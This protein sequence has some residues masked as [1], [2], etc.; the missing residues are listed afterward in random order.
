MTELKCST[1]QLSARLC[2]CV[3]L[4]TLCE[5]RLGGGTV[6][7]AATDVHKQPQLVGSLSSTASPALQQCLHVLS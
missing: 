3:R 2:G 4:Q 1:C 6:G 5:L 7:N